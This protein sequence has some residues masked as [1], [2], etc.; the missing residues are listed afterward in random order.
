MVSEPGLVWEVV[1]ERGTYVKH[2]LGEHREG[3]AV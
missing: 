3:I 1:S 2:L